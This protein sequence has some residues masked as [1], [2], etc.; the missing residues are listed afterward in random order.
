MGHIGLRNLFV[1]MAL[2]IVRFF[3]ILDLFIQTTLKTQQKSGL[4]LGKS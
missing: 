2:P 3:F 4:N 1:A